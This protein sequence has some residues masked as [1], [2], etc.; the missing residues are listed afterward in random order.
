MADIAAFPTITNVVVSEGHTLTYTGA[1]SLD[2]K[3]GMVVDYD[4]TGVNMT[5]QATLAASGDYPV[6]VAISN[7]DV[8]ASERF[9]VMIDGVGNLANYDDTTAILIGDWV[10]T[11]DN[12]VGGTIGVASIA[13]TA[14]TL[15]IIQANVVGQCLGTIAGG[16][17]GP[18]RI[19]PCVIT[20]ANSS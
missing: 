15:A 5:A 8:S 9:T 11:N 2:I 14:T 6:G 1:G 10:M 3:P 13:A 4:S 18:V 17:Y 7:S 19:A 16:S 12:A 20:R